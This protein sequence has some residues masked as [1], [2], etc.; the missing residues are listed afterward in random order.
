MSPN[1]STTDQLSELSGSTRDHVARQVAG[2]TGIEVKATIP[3]DQVDAALR[4]FN[5]TVDNDQERY[6]YFFDTPTLDLLEVGIIARARRIV[7][8]QHDSTVKFRPVVPSD[9][10]PEWVKVK[11]FK[12]EADASEKGVVRSA[13]LTV[14]VEKG[15]IKRVVAGKRPVEELFSKRQEEFLAA[16]GG[17]PVPFD[18]LT[19]FGPLEAHRW[20]LVDAACPW[21]ITV[22]LWRRS[23]GSQLMETSIKAPVAQA[24]AAMAGFMA[25]LAE[26]GAEKDL[27]QQTKTRWALVQS[28]EVGSPS[29]SASNTTVAQ[30]A[31]H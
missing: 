9:I 31:G 22:E 8:D 16:M 11:G 30:V 3:N 29:G 28:T 5:L 15:L 25:F 23:D 14:P 18:Q 20:Q 2:S 4:R 10:P 21:P 19:I 17:K 27:Q 6:I 13:S 1:A 7:G 24:A 12:L 26:I